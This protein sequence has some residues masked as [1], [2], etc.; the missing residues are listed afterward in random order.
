MNREHPMEPPY[1]VARECAHI[2]TIMLSSTACHSS[3]KTQGRV[4]G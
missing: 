1:K 3:P 4:L 2:T